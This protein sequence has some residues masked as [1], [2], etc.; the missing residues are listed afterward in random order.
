M[1]SPLLLLFLAS[2]RGAAA[3]SLPPRSP[4]SVASSSWPPP[5]VDKD[6]RWVEGVSAGPAGPLVDRALE[7][8]F[9][10]ALA[11]EAGGDV[12]ERGFAGIVTLSRVLVTRYRS[13]DAVSAASQRVLRGLFPDWPP[14]APAGRVGL[15]HWFAVLFARPFPAFSARLNAWVTSW[16]AQWLMGPCEV[17][18]L[19]EKVRSAAVTPGDGAR[20]QVLVKRCRFLEEAGC[21]SVC[22][23]ACKMPT[24]T[25]FN[26][27]M[28]VTMRMV[29]DY[30]T[31]ECRFQFGVAPT[32]ED[33]AEARAVP[34]FGACPAA[35]TLRQP[36]SDAAGG[37][38]CPGMG[39]A[40]SVGL[41]A[42]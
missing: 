40:E 11:A 30:E 3:L 39:A 33:E 12:E 8:K 17:Q 23:N 20:Q 6:A 10:A 38:S 16:A 28:G 21:A 7:A 19:D 13:G 9:R 4:T 32:A 26:E 18:D 27:D 41:P 35:A 34:C 29:P 42:Q 2:A 22:V 5:G 1:Q 24:Q 37:G 14:G 15:L 36:Q 31:L 25:F